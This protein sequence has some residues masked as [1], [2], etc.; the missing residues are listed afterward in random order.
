MK[1]TKNIYVQYTLLFILISCFWVSQF[2]FLN[3]TMVWEVDG[4]LQWFPLLTK[5][6]D[7]LVGLLSGDGLALW[8]WDIGL[9]GDLL[10]NVAHVLCDPFNFIVVF[11]PKSKIDIA[12]SVIIIV[13]LYTAGLIMLKFM[14][15][16]KKSLNLCLIGALS[17]AFCAWALASFVHLAFISQLV[18]FP[19]LIWGIDKLWNKEKP[20]LLMVGIIYSLCTGLYYTYMSALIVAVYVIVKYLN[21][22]EEKTVKYFIDKV[23]PI[24]GYSFLA[25]L[26]ASPIIAELLYTL[27]NVSTEAGK[28]YS[29]FPDIN[30]LLKYIPSYAGA[31]DANMN[32]AYLALNGLMLLAIPVLLF[33]KKKTTSMIMCIVMA[34]FMIFPIFQSLLNGMSYPSGRWCYAVGFFMAIA[35]VESLEIL[36]KDSLKYKKKTIITLAVIIAVTFI[37]AGTTGIVTIEQMIT[38]CVN[39]IFAFIIWKA[40]SSQSEDNKIRNIKWLVV[41]NIA[42]FAFVMY[43]PFLSDR[44]SIFL[45]QGNCYKGYEESSLS[46]VSRINDDSFYRVNTYWNPW[47]NDNGAVGHTAVNSSMYWRVP[48]THEYLSTLDSDWTKYNVNLGNSGG[49]F[50]RMTSLNNDSRCR[51]NFLQG[52]KYYL[53]D[54]KSDIVDYRGLNYNEY[55]DWGYKKINNDKIKTNI[56]E[57]KVKPSLGYVFDRVVS[58]KD[59]LNVSVEKRE[60]VL[61]SS[62]VVDDKDYSEM[63]KMR[64]TTDSC[65]YEKTKKIP[66]KIVENS[67]L[68]VPKMNRIFI[69]RDEQSIKLRLG[70]NIK[71]SEIYVVFKGIKKKPYTNKAVI[72]HEQKGALPLS[73]EDKFKRKMERVKNQPGGSF[74]IK[75]SRK[76]YGEGKIE[77]ELV[78]ASDE[79][80]GVQGLD[81][82]I[83]NLGYVEDYGD[84]ITCVF[85]NEGK[86]DYDSIEVLAVPTTEYNC[87]SKKLSAQG[88]KTTSIKND[89]ITGTVNAHN[90]GMLYLSIIKNEGWN[91][92]IDGKK[93]EKVYQVDNAF[94]GV[95][96]GK[97]HHRIKLT[98]NLIWI[99]YTIIA[100]I[101]G[102]LMVL[103]LIIKFLLNKQRNNRRS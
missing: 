93:V 22:R 84:D 29:I 53:S 9:G 52:I 17:Y 15:Y 87:Q 8:Q 13:K 41:I 55:V 21:E 60:Q 90:D 80:Q 33:T 62:L 11:F 103:I 57:S 1:R 47:Y 43:S 102:L 74:L 19:L 61:M 58:E 23:K 97:G 79:N 78:N 18:A 100:T 65:S 77:K 35:L 25:A 28:T 24:V 38:V 67:D 27:L 48:S 89:E 40:L 72:K 85:V 6:K 96:I 70:E 64:K 95:K 16:K 2:I 76:A 50:R 71:N 26:I 51:I 82:Y 36:L 81:N 12:Y 45:D 94:T 37:V 7:V 59:Y 66:F 54:K 86:Y 44:I 88:L 10:G 56:Y 73:R 31:V 5:T 30:L 99:K 101:V 3:K 68:V 46:E 49:N 4:Y 42:L 20:I 75:V 91:I 69:Q 92:Y 63:G 83:A 39:I 32:Y 98:Y 14:Q 34:V